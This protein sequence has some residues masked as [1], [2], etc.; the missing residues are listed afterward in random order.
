VG[1]NPIPSI[2]L[3]GHSSVVGENLGRDNIRVQK[4]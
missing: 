3:I 1:S 4:A 2:D